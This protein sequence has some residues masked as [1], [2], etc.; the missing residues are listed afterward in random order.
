MRIQRII[1]ALL[2]ATLLIGCGPSKNE[3]RAAF[4]RDCLQGFTPPQCKV[5]LAI[6]E[7]VHDI[8]SL[9]QWSVIMSTTAATN[10]VARGR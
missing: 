10:S 3:R 8:K 4:M 5:L 7:D 9:G 6:K 1:G 2:L